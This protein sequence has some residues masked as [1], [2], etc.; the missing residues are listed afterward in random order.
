MYVPVNI[1]VYHEMLLLY[2]PGASTSKLDFIYYGSKYMPLLVGTKYFITMR[3]TIVNKTLSRLKQPVRV[4]FVEGCFRA[5]KW[6]FFTSHCS[7]PQS[8]IGGPFSVFMSW[9]AHNRKQYY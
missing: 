6:P 5:P 3:V 1:R 7:S 9:V 2:V 4:P 8:W